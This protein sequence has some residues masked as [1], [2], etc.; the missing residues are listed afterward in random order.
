MFEYIQVYKCSYLLTKHAAI[1]DDKNMNPSLYES[2]INH[3]FTTF[4]LCVYN[5]MPH[6]LT[7]TETEKLTLRTNGQCLFLQV[8]QVILA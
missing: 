8:L 6:A 3:K 5:C 7:L 2:I 4:L 1:H